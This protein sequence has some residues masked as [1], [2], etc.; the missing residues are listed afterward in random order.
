MIPKLISE[1]R[2]RGKALSSSITKKGG[3]KKGKHDKMGIR[4]EE[5]KQ[6]RLIREGKEGDSICVDDGI[7]GEEGKK[8]ETGG[9]EMASFVWRKETEFFRKFPFG[10][11]RERS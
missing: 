5:G 11:E 8:K 2:E 9:K 7:M 4:F 1:T 10:S 3:K 6:L